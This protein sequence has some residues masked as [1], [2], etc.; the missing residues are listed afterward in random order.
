M[1]RWGFLHCHLALESK[2]VIARWEW[3]H[4]PLAL[5]SKV[6]V[7]RWAWQH[8]HLAVVYKK[9]VMARWA[10]QHYHLAF[11]EKV[12]MAWSSWQHYHI[13]MEE[14]GGWQGVHG[15]INGSRMVGM[16]A[17]PPAICSIW[18][19]FCDFIITLVLKLVLGAPWV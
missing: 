10:W 19:L 1:A 11:G 18:P 15:C 7:A 17:D 9:V 2:V 5:E 12:V 3:L 6:L 4:Y 8:Y 14:R 13:G 16:G